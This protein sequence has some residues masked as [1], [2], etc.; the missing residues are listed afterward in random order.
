MS[1]ELAD[2]T[3]HGLLEFQDILGQAL[4]QVTAGKGNERHG[5]GADLYQQPWMAIACTAGNGFLTGQAIKKAM[6][7]AASI[8]KPG[9]T[10]AR[11]EREVLGAIAYLAFAIMHQRSADANLD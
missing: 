4:E 8:N 11:F 10:G 7:A 6:E 3:D 1:I 9:Y 5:N 2:E